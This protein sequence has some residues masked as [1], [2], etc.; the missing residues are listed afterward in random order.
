MSIE[1]PIPDLPD[2]LSLYPWA[3]LVTAGAEGSP[4]ALAVPTVW[5][6]GA[7]RASV[8]ARTRDNLVARP[9]VSLLCPGTDGREYSL[10]IDG[11]A[12]VDGDEVAITPTW[13][14]LHRPALQGD[15]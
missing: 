8:G 6:D 2:R 13:A 5:R 14:V 4:R 7:L 12:A 1:V 15:E 10:I 3:F 9:T 11:T